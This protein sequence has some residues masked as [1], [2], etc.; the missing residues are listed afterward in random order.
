MKGKDVVPSQP[1]SWNYMTIV[2]SS[3]YW[4]DWDLW[5]IVRPEAK[6]ESNGPPA[7]TKHR[8]ARMKPIWVFILGKFERIVWIIDSEEDKSK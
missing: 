1:V 2:V 7:E 5:S 4:P 8:R 3:A 6:N